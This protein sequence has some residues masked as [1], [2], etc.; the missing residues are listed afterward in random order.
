M[1]LYKTV[2]GVV[3]EVQIKPNM[4][5]FRLKLDAGK[6]VAFCSC[7]PVKG[8]VNKEL[9]KQ[10]SRLLGEQVELVS[11]FTSR[12]KS[13]VVRGTN[14]EKVEQILKSACNIS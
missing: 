4:R 9:I 7:P 8:K 12:Q 2:E 11:G 6:L 1:K 10:F 3:F 5:Q 14:L 13:F